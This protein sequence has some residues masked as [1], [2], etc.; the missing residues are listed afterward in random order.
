MLPPRALLLSDL[1]S[2]PSTHDRCHLLESLTMPTSASPAA[3]S[4]V[5]VI[6]AG[7]IGSAWAIC[8]A[9]A[10]H[11]V[12][13]NDRSHEI[14]TIAREVIAT[15]LQDMAEF[16]L[17]EDTPEA[18]LA[19]VTC[20]T[21]L[22]SCLDGVVHVQECA[23]ESIPAKKALFEQLGEMTGPE[24]VLASSTSAFIPSLFTAEV[25][26][27]ERCIVAHP[28]NPPY[29]V[30][31]VQMVPAPWT[32][33]AVID[34]TEALMVAAGQAPIRLEKE[35]DGFVVNRLQ[36]ALIHEA[37]RIVDEGVA[38]AKA[39]D[40][41]IS[42]GLGLRWSFMG[43]FETMELNA[44]NGIRDYVERYGD[45]YRRIIG[46]GEDA[47]PLWNGKALD[48]IEADR[49]AILDRSRI[50][51]RQRW[52]DRRLMDLAAAMKAAEARTRWED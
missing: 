25:R 24:V 44:P 50:A 23:P 28:I 27:R 30:P 39:I 36:G 42:K 2:S 4:P 35:A 51:E 18:I 21:D 17:L 34:Q 38:G 32:A 45:L 13:L 22:A 5:A 16:D 11:P 12:R 7:L 52:R 43:P 9:R 31:V 1:P 19:R 15:A 47:A 10:G 46:V 26:H 37:L 33:P 49:S 40:L 20:S 14:L 29:L 8:F 6:G 41:A 48:R 3:K